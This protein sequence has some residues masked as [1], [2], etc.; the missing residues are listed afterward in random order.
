MADVLVAHSGG[1]REA[2]NRE[3]RLALEEA[4]AA[5]D[6]VDVGLVDEGRRRDESQQIAEDGAVRVDERLAQLRRWG[7]LAA[8]DERGLLGTEVVEER[9]RRDLARRA[10]LLHGDVLGAVLEGELDR[11]LLHPAIG[12]LA[13]GL[14]ATKFFGLRGAYCRRGRPRR[15]V[16]HNLHFCRLCKICQV[17]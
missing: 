2:L 7:A 3:L 17:G 15:R 4:A 6:E 8:P 14:S 16:L 10:D 11:G 9:A 13:L 12:T 5:A 1:A